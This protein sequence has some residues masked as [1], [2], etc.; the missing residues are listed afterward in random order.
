[1]KTTKYRAWDKVR[2]KMFN[3]LAITFDIKTQETFALSI[4]GRSWEPIDK[5]EL[6]QWTGLKDQEGQD[7]YEGDRLKIGPRQYTVTW[8]DA[9]AC[10]R[11][12]SNTPVENTSLN[13]VTSG[14]VIGHRYEDS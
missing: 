7:V 14:R 9:E 2:K 11:L 5:F 10:F 8:V 4:P 6:L 13:E 12:E 3:I 1:M